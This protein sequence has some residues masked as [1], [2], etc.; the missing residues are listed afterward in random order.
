MFEDNSEGG[1]MDQNKKKSSLKTYVR[2]LLPT[3]GHFVFMCLLNNLYL[4]K[5]LNDWVEIL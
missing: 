5:G 2:P 4:W 3:I 1:Y